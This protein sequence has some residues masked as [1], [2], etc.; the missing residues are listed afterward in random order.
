[1]QVDGVQCA[2]KCQCVNA[3]KS[4]G[5]RPAIYRCEYTSDESGHGLRAVVVTNKGSFTVFVPNHYSQG[6]LFRRSA[7]PTVPYSVRVRVR[8]R[9]NG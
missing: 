3:G 7:I 2:A 9:F 4:A 8:V 1:M 5:N 6:P